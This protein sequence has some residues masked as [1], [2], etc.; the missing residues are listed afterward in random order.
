MN[1]KHLGDNVSLLTTN[2]GDEVL[3]SYEKPVAGFSPKIGWYKNSEKYSVSSSEHV[4]E[5]LKNVHKI[6]RMTLQEIEMMFL[7][8]SR[9]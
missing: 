3:F 6:T 8:N 1:I 2:H 9:G 5:Y 7:I 4:I